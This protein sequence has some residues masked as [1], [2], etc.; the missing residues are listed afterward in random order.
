M[1][2][3]RDELLKKFDNTDDETLKQTIRTVAAALGASDRQTDNIISN[4][5]TFKKKVR[6]M[7]ESDI[8]KAVSK[9]GEDKADEIYKQ[10]RL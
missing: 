4:L 5:N 7:S 1:N 9:I 3:N 10:L 6:N 2:Y 8:Q